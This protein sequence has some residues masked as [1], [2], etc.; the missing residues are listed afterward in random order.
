MLA[1]LINGGFFVFDVFF[2]VFLAL[3]S[4]SL[5]VSFMAC[6]AVA[7]CIYLVISLFRRV[8]K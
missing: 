4:M 2:D 7:G 8:D 6:G 5:F 3:P 1:F